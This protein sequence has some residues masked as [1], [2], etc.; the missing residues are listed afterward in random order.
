MSTLPDIWP[1]HDSVSDAL[2]ALANPTRFDVQAREAFADCFL[3]KRKAT[4]Q[5][6]IALSR[7]AFW[8][9]YY[10]EHVAQERLPIAEPVIATDA[11]ASYRYACL[12]VHLGDFVTNSKRFPLGELAVAKDERLFYFY[13]RAVLKCRWE[14][15]VT[16]PEVLE[17]YRQTL[18]LS[19]LKDLYNKE[20][21]S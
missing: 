12:A 16:D 15:A 6:E 2:Q 11:H 4:E 17:A 8:A 19:Y 10:C 7:S 5:E 13:A 3:G 21:P 18:E 9:A 14:N 20:I 1:D